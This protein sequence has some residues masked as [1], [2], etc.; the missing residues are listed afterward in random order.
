MSIERLS[1]ELNKI[2]FKNDY[3]FVKNFK[4]DTFYVHKRLL[5]KFHQKINLEKF[6][7]IPQK[8]W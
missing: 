8:S 6:E 5:N 4:V 2:L 7:Q 1:S 3:I